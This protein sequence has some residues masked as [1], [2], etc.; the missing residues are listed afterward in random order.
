M[1]IEEA[2][3]YFLS[4]RQVDQI[5][6]LYTTMDLMTESPMLKNADC[7][8]IIVEGHIK[9]RKDFREKCKSELWGSK[10]FEKLQKGLKK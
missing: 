10:H 9:E 4:S 5:E 6:M 1:T 7:L 2:E 3:D 8:K